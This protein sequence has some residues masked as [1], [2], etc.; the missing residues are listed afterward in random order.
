MERV[1]DRREAGGPVKV[2]ADG[3]GVALSFI[4]EDDLAFHMKTCQT[5]LDNR[6]KGEGQMLYPA[7][8]SY[9]H[10]G[11]PEGDRDNLHRET[12]FMAAVVSTAPP[13]ELQ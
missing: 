3:R 8:L 5:L 10:P 12:I 13:E 1:L 7:V 11:I 6:K 2:F 9:S 4:D